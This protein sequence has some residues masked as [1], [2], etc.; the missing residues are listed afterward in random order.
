[1][2]GNVTMQIQVCTESEKNEIGGRKRIWETAQELEGF[3]DLSGGDSKYT[4]HNAKI[5]EST[6]I[7]IAEYEELDSRI[8]PENSKAVIG[9][10]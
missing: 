5:Q 8:K 7:F 1:M 6:H 2:G 3:L 4:I 10:R 9:A